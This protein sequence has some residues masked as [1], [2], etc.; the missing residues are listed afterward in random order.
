M[1]LNIIGSNLLPPPPPPPTTHTY[2]HIYTHARTRAHAQHTHSRAPPPQERVRSLIEERKK[3]IDEGWAEDSKGPPGA[4]PSASSMAPEGSR[5][6]TKSE[7]VEKERARLEVLKRRQ[8]KELQ[9]V[10]EGRGGE[11]RGGG[12]LCWRCARISRC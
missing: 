8:E 2:V 12:A 5:K 9:Q 3:L 10:W 7:M 1:S 6:M 4:K 11:A